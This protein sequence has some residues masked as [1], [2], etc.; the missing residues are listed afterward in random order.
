MPWPMADLCNKARRT[1]RNPP[2]P[3]QLLAL[4]TPGARIARRAAGLVAVAQA[5]GAQY[6]CGEFEEVFG[7]GVRGGVGTALTAQSIG[8]AATE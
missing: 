1:D 4:V 2:R 6:G 7:V 3:L 5:Q 8:A